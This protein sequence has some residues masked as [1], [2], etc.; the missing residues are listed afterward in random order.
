MNDKR[1]K[2]IC[3][4]AIK[5]RE[6][7]D[8]TLSENPLGPSPKVKEAI[9]SAIDTV[10]Y[11]VNNEEML[12]NLIAAHHSISVDTI[13]LGAGANGLL[14]DFLNAFALNKNI[15]APIATFPESV[16]Q[17]S[18]IGGSVE[19]VPLMPDMGLDLQALLN[20]INSNTGL[21]HFCNP[22]NPTGI[23]T[24]TDQILS[25]ADRSPVPLLIS[26]VGSEFIGDSVIGSLHPNIII[27]RSF[28]KVY[29]LAGLRVGYS[30]AQKELTDRV[31]S[32]LISYRVS[33]MAIDAAIAAMLDEGHVQ[34]SI[35]YILR[36][37]EI[38]MS[39]MQALG[40]DI[41]PSNGQT[42]IAKVPSKFKDADTFCDIIKK[43]GVA[44]VNCS[45]YDGLEQYI[46]IS[47]QSKETNYKYLE[48]LKLLGEIKND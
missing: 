22:N 35:E 28:S 27:I 8:L 12:I 4:Y 36:E 39:S 11:Y 19:F 17:M 31:R 1:S 48:I 21:I 32:Q 23:W 13:L 14:Q 38:L 34:K 5:N 26:E 43:Y 18:T 9:I 40:F 47:P 20:R 3:T 6:Q 41:T 44:V 25:L 46:R 42:F 37:K 29:G 45:I 2:N 16:A 30:I 33:G 15:I 10:S 24:N 7:I